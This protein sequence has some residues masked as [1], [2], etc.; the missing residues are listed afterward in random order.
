MNKPDKSPQKI[1][2]MFDEI[3]GTYD[4]LNHLFTFNLD[5][6]WRKSLVDRIVSEGMP[7]ADIL[8]LATGTGDL[9]LE[10]ARM[11]EA[12]ITGADF[13]R[14]MLKYQSEK[15][16]HPRINLVH[17]DAEDLPFEDSAFDIV[18]IGFGV[19]NFMNTTAC[20]EEIRR[21]LR[22]GGHLIVLEIFKGRG[23]PNK[24]F[25]LYFGNL[26][27]AIGN[28]VSGKSRAY[29]YLFHSVESFL[30]VNEFAG[31]AN[32]CGFEAT[33]IRNNFIGIVNTV[34]LRRI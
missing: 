14:E 30:T 7:R 25:N 17:A 13:S 2:S 12:R 19:R 34:F 1:A 22:P 27:P 31:I 11:P 8:D 20:L 6:L 16:P 4:G 29:S 28:A 3:A 33:N 32:S 26:V 18:T 21:V 23:L 10:L 5:K 15:K 9:A 24:I